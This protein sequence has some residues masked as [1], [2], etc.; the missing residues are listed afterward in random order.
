MWPLLIKIINHIV[1]VPIKILILKGFLEMFA[2]IL[3]R[4]SSYNIH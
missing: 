3:I 4:E 2:I 1:I